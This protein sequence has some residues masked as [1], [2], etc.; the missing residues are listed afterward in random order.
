LASFQ[1]VFI[2]DSVYDANVKAYLVEDSY[3]ADVVGR[4]VNSLHDADLKVFIVPD[5]YNA[6]IRL[7]LESKPENTSFCF[8]S[9][10][11]IKAK[12]LP[13]N[14]YEL[15]TLRK[16]RDEYLRHTEEGRDLIEEYY[17]IAPK[18]IENIDKEADAINIY[19]NLYNE[20]VMASI[21][22]INENQLES[23]KNHYINIV[24]FLKEKYLIKA[25]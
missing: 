9:T 22:L 4:V 21:R 1:K 11:C 25:F 6:N 12:G 17:A 18:I 16:F 20:L 8:L 15:N 23:A 5:K 24:N 14:C 3:N 19:D 2:V 7:C 10:A 13:D